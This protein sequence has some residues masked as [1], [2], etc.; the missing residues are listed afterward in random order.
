[1]AILLEVSPG[2]SL[3]ASFVMSLGTS[4]MTSLSFGNLS[5]N[6]VLQWSVSCLHGEKIFESFQRG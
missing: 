1:M 6:C 3:G 4:L 5:D 2:I